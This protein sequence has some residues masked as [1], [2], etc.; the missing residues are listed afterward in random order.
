MI[1]RI[2]T[3]TNEA[4]TICTDFSDVALT[5]NWSIGLVAEVLSTSNVLPKTSVGI[6]ADAAAL[7]AGSS[8]QDALKQLL[9]ADM[10]F[11][12][13]IDPT[14]IDISGLKAVAASGRRRLQSTSVQFEFIILAPNA[15]TVLADFSAQLSSADSKLRQSTTAGTMVPSSLSFT[16]ECAQGLYRPEGSKNCLSCPGNSIPNVDTKY[17]SC[18][19]CG[20]REAPDPQKPWNCVC[21]P[22]SFNTSRAPSCHD[23]D[24]SP[25]KVKKDWPVIKCESC[26]TLDCA[27]NTVECPGG[28]GLSVDQGYVLMTNEGGYDTIFQ[29]DNDFA[30]PGGNFQ[31]LSSSSNGTACGPGHTGLACAVC[32]DGYEMKDG[33]CSSCED[34]GYWGIAQLV[35]LIA[36]AAVMATQVKKW[37]QY[38]TIC[39]SVV[40]ALPE[41]KATAKIFISTFQIIGGLANVLSVDFP[42]Q[43]HD[44]LSHFVSA[45]R[46][47]FTLKLGLG[48]LA[49]GGYIPSVLANIGLVILVLLAVLVVHAFRMRAISKGET[50][51]EKKKAVM[52]AIFDKFDEDG[53][54]IELT[55]MQR[56]CEKVDPNI[57]GDRAISPIINRMFV[58]S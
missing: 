1:G 50:D 7:V 3:A 32:E 23:T 51:E 15:S 40:D 43:F 25:S 41:I 53:T 2:G 42:K 5:G 19:V 11:A 6:T 54:G 45:F 22:G 30:C 12:L 35:G 57:T 29:C 8:A 55:E 21:E 13:S 58:Q 44:F 27:G 28:T 37:F 10:A 20:L 17:A 38:A 48:C 16:F 34:R 14:E 47:D 31:P 26:D 4:R 18:T 9:R 52:K 24:Y 33:Q 39:E 56:I 46:F 49:E 36:F